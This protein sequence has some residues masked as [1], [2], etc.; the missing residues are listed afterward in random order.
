MPT[1]TITFVNGISWTGSPPSITLTINQTINPGEALAI[2]CATNLSTATTGAIL[3]NDPTVGIISPVTQVSPT[4][5]NVVQAIYARKYATGLASGSIIT[6]TPSSGTFGTQ[7][8]V[9]AAKI[10]GINTV[11]NYASLGGTLTGGTGYGLGFTDTNGTVVSSGR[12]LNAAVFWATVASANTALT[13]LAAGLG[14]LTSSTS[15][16]ISISSFQR[17]WTFHPPSMQGIAQWGTTAT[18]AITAVSFVI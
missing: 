18:F 10:T 6:F 9:Y 12:R 11:Q 3:A 17:C 7:S 4:G 14:G 5:Q 1:Q 15:A 2:V 13:G 16:S 8:Y